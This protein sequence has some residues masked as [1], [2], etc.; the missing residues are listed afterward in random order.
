ML[1]NYI[2]PLVIDDITRSTA[3]SSVD[4]TGRGKYTTL[5][6]ATARPASRRQ[7]FSDSLS[8]LGPSIGQSRAAA[9][10]NV[11][12]LRWLDRCRKT[13]GSLGATA[14][15]VTERERTDCWGEWTSRRTVTTWSSCCRCSSRRIG[16]GGTVL[17]P[18]Q[19]KLNSRRQSQDTQ[20][21]ASCFCEQPGV[22]HAVSCGAYAGA[23]DSAEGFIQVKGCFEREVSEPRDG[24]SQDYCQGR[25]MSKSY[26]H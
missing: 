6:A 21:A 18:K 2:N 10:P 24:M 1:R 19:G 17:N 26:L 20:N 25:E 16:F 9:N 8:C 11:V 12:M 22:A 15:S 14:Q 7:G 3:K 5:R 13:C 23:G 4:E